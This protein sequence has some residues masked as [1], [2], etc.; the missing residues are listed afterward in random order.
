MKLFA[1]I[2]KVDAKQ[3]LVYGV[4]A[5]EA[6]DK[7]GEIFDY[8]SSKPYVQ[9]WSAEFDKATDGAS[10]GN[11][12]AQHSS[13][14]AG[15]LIGIDFDDAHKRIEI[16]AKIVDDNEWKKVEE[17]VYTGFSIGGSYIRRWPDGDAMRYTARPN[18]VSIVDNPCM[19]GAHFTMI[20]ADGSEE[21]RNFGKAA[22]TKRVGDK[23]LTSEHFAYVGDP[24]KTDT[25]KL[26]IHDANHVRNA[27][28]R[29]DQT[30][31]IP[32]SEKA[33]V[34]ARIVEAA[35]KHGNEVSGEAGK[36]ADGADKFN[37]ESND[38][39]NER[40][41]AL[42]KQ[43]ETLTMQHA[44][45]KKASEAH[46]A[47]LHGLKAAHDLMGHHLMKMCD[48]SYKADLPDNVKKWLGEQGITSS[49]AGTSGSD[50]KSAELEKKVDALT[51]SVAEL[52]KGLGEALAARKHDLP[53]GAVRN[54]N[55][56]TITKS[57]DGAKKDSSDDGKVFAKAADMPVSVRS[58]FL[59]KPMSP[60]S[61]LARQ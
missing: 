40:I 1:Q 31:G 57:E 21:D 24:E 44:E 18:E 49:A 46:A 51:T 2:T 60:E 36:S 37:K 35:H 47:H 45:L 14:A 6:V 26:P 19:R 28:A 10:L 59:S 7:A 12:R 30:E 56:V 25:W 43:V 3:H 23:D 50:P 33:A 39:S 48:A 53:A 11:V 27:L 38:M 20:K 15:K 5:E 55:V 34:Y 29:F 8:S 13:I 4:M 58:A 16:A 54:G 42:T 32:Q 41:D 22:K 17:G 9:A 61:F 52:V